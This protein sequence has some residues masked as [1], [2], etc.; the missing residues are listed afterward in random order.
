MTGLQLCAHKRLKALLFDEMSPLF[1]LN[2]G[3]LPGGCRRPLFSRT[4]SGRACPALWFN[5]QDAYLD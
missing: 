1:A 2:Y 5:R 4:H 3:P